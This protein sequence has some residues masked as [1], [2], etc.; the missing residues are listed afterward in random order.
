MPIIALLTGTIGWKINNVYPLSFKSHCLIIWY[1][2]GEDIKRISG[3][4][5][6]ARAMN[7]VTYLVAGSEWAPTP[8]LNGPFPL[9][10]EI[11]Y[12]RAYQRDTYLG[13]GLYPQ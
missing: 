12:I 2:D 13:N 7:I 11:D 6:A 1:I 3:P 8:E 5:V 10:F 4:H 9:Q